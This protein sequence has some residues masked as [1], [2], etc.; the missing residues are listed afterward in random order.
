MMSRSAVGL[1]VIY[2]TDEQNSKNSSLQE[3]DRLL[4]IV[5]LFFQLGRKKAYC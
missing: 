2:K 1:L 4:F 5:S 3:T